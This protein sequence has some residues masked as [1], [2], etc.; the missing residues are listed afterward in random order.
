MVDTDCSLKRPDRVM[1][2]QAI[3]YLMGNMDITYFVRTSTNHAPLPLSGG[4]TL[5]KISLNPLGSC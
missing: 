1:V 2:N 5:N 3:L 4:V